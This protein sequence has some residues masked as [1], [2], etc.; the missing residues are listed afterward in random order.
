MLLVGGVFSDLD[1]FIVYLLLVY[2][3]YVVIID[4][5]GSVDVVDC[6]VGWLV[7]GIYVV[8]LNK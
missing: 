1:V 4:C 2:L 5:S 8:M 6:Y 7:V 3:L